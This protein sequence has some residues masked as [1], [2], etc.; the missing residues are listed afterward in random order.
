M[1]DNCLYYTHSVFYPNDESDL[2]QITRE[3]T[4]RTPYSTS[5]TEDLH[6][7]IRNVIEFYD[8]EKEKFIDK[9]ES[10]F[11][12]TYND[13]IG[14]YSDSYYIDTMKD[15]R[16][17]YKAL[18]RKIESKQREEISELKHELREIKKGNDYIWNE[19]AQE[20]LNREF[21]KKIK[22]ISDNFDNFSENYNNLL[23]MFDEET[24]KKNQAREKIQ[25]DKQE[26][27]K[28]LMIELDKLEK[29]LELGF[30]KKLV[31]LVSKIRTLD[32]RDIEQFSD[33]NVEEVSIH[34]KETFDYWER[35]GKDSQVYDRH[36]DNFQ[37]FE[38]AYGIMATRINTSEIN[39]ETK[40]L[41]N[42]QK[43]KNQYKDMLLE[44]HIKLEENSL[45]LENVVSFVN[46]V[47]KIK[48]SAKKI[49]SL[50][51]GIKRYVEHKL[52]DLLPLK[53]LLL[54]PFKPNKLNT[55][56]DD[57]EDDIDKKERD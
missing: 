29:N 22:K 53:D 23:K 25:E 34:I 56:L 10:R 44:H 3:I 1:R 41:K 28:P 31:A 47:E 30:Q 38:N 57:F 52:Y 4:V 18:P 36:F 32:V 12:N 2:K 55:D 21:N 5:E 9:V 42:I 7:E 14:Q 43:Q 54:K 51:K 26:E 33:K 49:T 27:L 24:N 37:D 16:D 45:F 19:E 39:K 6:E 20:E 17:I 40:R 46:R 48:K 15:F 50:A 11:V 13:F 35:S 8:T